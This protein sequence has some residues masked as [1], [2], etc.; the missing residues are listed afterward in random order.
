MPHQEWG[1]AVAVGPSSISKTSG[2][3][4]DGIH[5]AQP[6]KVGG[7]TISKELERLW[8]EGIIQKRK[9]AAHGVDVEKKILYDRA[10]HLFV[11]HHPAFAGNEASSYENGM[12]VV[13]MAIT[14]QQWDSILEGS[15]DGTASRLMFASIE[16]ESLETCLQL[17]VETGLKERGKKCS[18]KAGLHSVG[19]RFRVIK[20][21]WK[22]L[23]NSDLEIA[24]MILRRVGDGGGQ[25]QTS[26][27]NY[28]G[29]KK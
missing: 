4:L 9:L 27:R 21:K 12:T 8:N 18:A 6:L 10:Q 22:E 29:G 16:K 25:E 2:S 13:A 5:T 24:N 7:V 26:I 28:F 11:G 3:V 19:S 15:L 1:A 17:E 20:K 14:K 23:G